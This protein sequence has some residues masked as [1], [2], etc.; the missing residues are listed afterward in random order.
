MVCLVHTPSTTF[1]DGNTLAVVMDYGSSTDTYDW[2]VFTVSRSL[3]IYSEIVITSSVNP[4]Q[5]YF[6]RAKNETTGN[7]LYSSAATYYNY[8]T[9]LGRATWRWAVRHDYYAGFMSPDPSWPVASQL[10]NYGF[11]FI[12][13]A[14]HTFKLY[15]S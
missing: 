5:S 12:P 2:S 4:T 10:F 11:G 14:T 15:T 7:Q 6:A 9:G 1:P 3:D 8:D 13:S